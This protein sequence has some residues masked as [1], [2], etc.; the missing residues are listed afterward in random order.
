MISEHDKQAILNGAFG[1][2]RAGHKVSCVGTIASSYYKRLFVVEKDGSDKTMC[3]YSDELKCSHVRSGLDIVG[4][5][6][7]RPIPFNL[8]EALTGKPFR[9]HFGEKT[10]LLADVRENAQNEL[11]P[12]IG[13]TIRSNGTIIAFNCD[14]SSLAGCT[15][16]RA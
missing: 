5:W 4:L 9:N 11:K 7:D 3:V 15:M 1:V 14:L 16:W 2:T 8:E 10:Y 6:E 13:Y 12:F